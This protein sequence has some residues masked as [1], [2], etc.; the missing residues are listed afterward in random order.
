MLALKPF[1]GS[2]PGVADLL[3]WATLMDDGLVINKDGSLMA[4]WTFKGPDVAS[5][6]PALKNAITQ[7]LNNAS[8]LGDGYAFWF[9][10]VR[11]PAADYPPPSA[12]HFPDPTSALIDEE[13]RRQF[14]AEGAHFET[15]QA[16][17]LMY[18]P[19]I[20]HQ[21]YVLNRFYSGGGKAAPVSDRH[22]ETFGRAC[23][24]LED[25]LADVLIN[26]RRMGRLDYVDRNG[27][28]HTQDEL[29]N[30][31]HRCLTG[32]DYGVNIAPG[33]MHLDGIIGGQELWTGDSPKLGR[34]FTA[35]IGIEGFPAE[36]YPFILDELSDLPFAYRFSSRFI[37]LSDQTT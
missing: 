9:E 21:S 27:R 26:F 36:S 22:V 23:Q 37:L 35:C 3:P 32:E 2:E 31:L 19:P 17:V 5:L 1:R 34:M 24:S 30:F 18:T 10:T 12:S 11:M 28:E 20:R 7:R 16:V 25:I 33:A 15:G 13:R 14:M 6:T 4:G 29:V 8:L